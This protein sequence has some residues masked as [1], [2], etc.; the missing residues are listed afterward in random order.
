MDRKRENRMGDTGVMDI[1]EIQEILPH[2]Y[3]FLMIDRVVE[4]AQGKSIVAIKNLTI[5]EPQFAGHFPEFPVMPGVMMIE[6]IAQAAGLMIGATR[7]DGKP[8]IYFLAKVNNAIFKRPAV[9]GDQLQIEVN[10]QKWRP[11]FCV[12]EGQV[13]V[14]GKLVCSAEVTCVRPRELNL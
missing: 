4:R 12:A 13:T 14:D 2:R 6:A 11:G 1:R 8:D 3:P 10:V 9:P 5:N 7:E